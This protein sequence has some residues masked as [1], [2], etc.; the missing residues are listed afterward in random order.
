MRK[1]ER[2]KYDVLRQGVRTARMEPIVR[3]LDEAE[4][5]RYRILCE[6]PSRTSIESGEQKKIEMMAGARRGAAERFQIRRFS[7]EAI[8][9]KLHDDPGNL[10]LQRLWLREW[11]ATCYPS[12]AAL[13]TEMSMRG[14]YVPR[15]SPLARQALEAVLYSVDFTLMELI[16]QDP[17]QRKSFLSNLTTMLEPFR[18]RRSPRPEQGDLIDLHEAFGFTGKGSGNRSHDSQTL[19]RDFWD[20]ACF[21]VHIVYLSGVRETPAIARIAKM[22]TRKGDILKND[23]LRKRYSEWKEHPV[24][25]RWLSNGD[26]IAREFLASPHCQ[27]LLKTAFPIPPREPRPHRP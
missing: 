25:K 26:D 14:E 8:S 12:Y 16:L 3:Y 22:H 17:D 1:P 9:K 19:S 24:R 18:Q 15:E 11:T 21:D 5:G 27:E 13:K 7:L 4:A 20:G 6:N 10:E 2:K 23:T